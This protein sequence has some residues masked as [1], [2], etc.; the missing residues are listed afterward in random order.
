MTT[1]EQRAEIDAMRKRAEEFGNDPEALNFRKFRMKAEDKA[2][3]A[4]GTISDLLTGVTDVTFEEIDKCR[5]ALLTLNQIAHVY[6]TMPSG[7]TLGRQRVIEHMHALAKKA[8]DDFD[9]VLS[10]TNPESIV[11]AIDRME[12][13]FKADKMMAELPPE[14]RTPEAR[15][16]IEPPRP[17]GKK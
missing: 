17:Y 15:R 2:K 7:Q 13:S 10:W 4:A 14:L 6:R 16:E 5:A 12:K 9:A 11:D 3:Q 8:Q 1:E